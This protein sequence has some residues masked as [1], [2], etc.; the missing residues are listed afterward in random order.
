M[1]RFDPF[2]TQIFCNRATDADDNMPPA[3]NHSTA[4]LRYV[5]ADVWA[6]PLVILSKNV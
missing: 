2:L 6:M 5:L 4:R 3:I 1:N